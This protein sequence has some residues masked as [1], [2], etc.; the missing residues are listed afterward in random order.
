MLDRTCGTITTW[1]VLAAIF[2]GTSETIT[3]FSL[4]L[5][6]LSLVNATIEVSTKLGHPCLLGSTT[7]VQLLFAWDPAAME[8]L[9]YSRIVPLPSLHVYT[10][11]AR[12]TLSFFFFVSWQLETRLLCRAFAGHRLR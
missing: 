7:H 1:R 2:L 10:R 8:P 3:E 12:L 11:V 9:N 4:D 5:L 6:R